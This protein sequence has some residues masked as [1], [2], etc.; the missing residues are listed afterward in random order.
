MGL[1]WS[2]LFL[3]SPSPRGQQDSDSERR[4]RAM[5][6]LRAWRE[7]ETLLVAEELRT[8]DQLARATNDA[9]NA[10]SMSED[11]AFG[12]LEH[13]YRNY[14]ELEYRFEILR[15]GTDAD[16]EELWR[17]SRGVLNAA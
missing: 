3:D 17:Q 2:A 15:T 16:A 13:A 9:F 6:G 10:G 14:S 4:R 8:R 12:Y 1:T 7:T 11:E 5:E